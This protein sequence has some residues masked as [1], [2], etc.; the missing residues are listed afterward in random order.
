MKKTSKRD[1]SGRYN[2]IILRC[3]NTLLSVVI[4]SIPN[5]LV[6][7]QQDAKMKI[8]PN[9]MFLEETD[10]YSK[11]NEMVLKLFIFHLH[12]TNIAGYDHIPCI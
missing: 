8:S 4:A 3:P 1:W 9:E 7:A 10:K 11:F 2:T 12:C 6:Q 5:K